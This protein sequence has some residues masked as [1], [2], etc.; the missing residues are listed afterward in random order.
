MFSSK[1]GDLGAG[2]DFV[3]LNAFDNENDYGKH[4]F[5]NYIVKDIT[6]PKVYRY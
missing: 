4:I 2:G 6:N 1:E 5:F 3:G